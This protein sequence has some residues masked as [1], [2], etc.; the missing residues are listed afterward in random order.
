MRTYIA[1]AAVATMA[2]ASSVRNME[3]RLIALPNLPTRL[4]PLTADPNDLAKFH[5]SLV[6]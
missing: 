1:L 2:A 6:D 5:G 3:T 4:T